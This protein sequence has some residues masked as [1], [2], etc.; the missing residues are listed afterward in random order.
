MPETMFEIVE[1]LGIL[2]PLGSRAAPGGLCELTSL[3]DIAVRAVQVLGQ[4]DAAAG[5]RESTAA[6]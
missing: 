6:G 2:A 4:P 1:V 5:E 3:V